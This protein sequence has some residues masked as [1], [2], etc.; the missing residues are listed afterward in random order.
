MNIPTFEKFGAE[1]LQNKEKIAKQLL[2]YYQGDS[3]N[4]ACGSKAE[5]LSFLSGKTSAGKQALL[6]FLDE[7]ED[8][9]CMI[10]R[11]YDKGL[12]T[13][14]FGDEWK[15]LWEDSV[16]KGEWQQYT[17]PVYYNALVQSVK[18][19]NGNGMLLYRALT[20]PSDKMVLDAVV[21]SYNYRGAG[22][23]WSY[24]FNGAIDYE[25]QLS[26]DTHTY[27][28]EIR[29]PYGCINA[30]KTLYK[31]LY[32]L[33]NEREIELSNATVELVNM[34]VQID[35]DSYAVKKIKMPTKTRSSDDATRFAK[36]QVPFDMKIKI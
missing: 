8:A 11:M 5:L 6:R 16:A 21:S 2:G 12:I 24:S 26:D 22:I 18:K 1:R 36:L 20:V 33:A 27:I 34:W 19:Q 3:T 31:S 7:P 35:K 10:Q 17:K 25:S 30:A 23:Y 29:S 13:D 15:P 28:M 9:D 32:P 14:S 4:V